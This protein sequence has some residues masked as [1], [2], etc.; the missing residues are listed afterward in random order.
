M[1]YTFIANLRAPQHIAIN[2]K[3][4]FQFF[5][6]SVFLFF[7]FFVVVFLPAYNKF[8]AGYIN[9]PTHTT[10]SRCGRGNKGMG[11][12]MGRSGM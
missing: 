3:K 2:H 10:V 6:L 7:C 4:V 9:A 11:A 8:F 1:C 12:V 5:S